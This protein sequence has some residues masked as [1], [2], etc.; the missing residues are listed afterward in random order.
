MLNQE[1]LSR[2]PRG[3]CEG[4]YRGITGNCG[5]IPPPK[6]APIKFERN[7]ACRASVPRLANQIEHDHAQ[8]IPRTPLDVGLL[9][10]QKVE[11]ERIANID[12]VH[13]IAT[14]FRVPL[15]SQSAAGGAAS[16]GVT[17]FF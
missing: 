9:S 16:G 15:E 5:T 4:Y 3:H 2:A 17:A 8:K 12:A 6:T 13:E 7:L 14:A 11:I 10:M 1:N